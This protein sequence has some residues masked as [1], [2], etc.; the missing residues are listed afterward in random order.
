MLAKK[1][2]LCL[3]Q[4]VGPAVI[5][6][7]LCCSL[8]HPLPLEPGKPDPTYVGM[9]QIEAAGRSFLQ[10]ANDSEATSDEKPVFSAGFSYNYWLDTTD[11]TQ[12]EYTGITGKIPV[13]DSSGFGVGD[14]YPVYNVSWLD[15]ALFCNAKSKKEHLDTVYSYYGTPQVQNGSVYDIAG[16]QIHYDRNGFRLP[17]ESEWEFAARE[18][19]SRIP[20]PGLE[21]TATADSYAWYSANSQGK[22][23]PV[24]GR[25]PN[26]YGLYDMAGNVYEWTG[27]WKG[28]YST[29]SII[30]SIGA[31]MP[32]SDIEKVIKGGSFESGFISLRPSRRGAT[33]PSSQSTVA[34]YIGFRCARGIIAGP[35]FINGDTSSA[36]TNPAVLTVTSIMPIIGTSDARVVFVN[37]TG[38]IRTLCFVDFSGSYPIVREV[39]DI[40]TVYDPA[41]SPNGKY[42]AFCTRNAIGST[43]ESA[44]YVRKL[45]S[46]SSPPVKLASDS[47][48]V[49]R[50]WVDP[51]LKDTFLIYTNSAID[52]TSACGPARKH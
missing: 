9:K 26:A 1:N 31:Q 42:V 15:A 52:N 32:N 10:G 19:S 5:G 14:R 36:L 21:D 7:L 47:A 22:T 12:K 37:V 39:K 3:L 16:M 18:G 13:S 20:F 30:N 46:L 27:D 25:L 28:P 35:A 51:S 11:V 34:E 38:N 41:I 50:W 45:D 6:A 33:Y 29:S 48:F 17:T 23:N 44:I 8:F 43:G 40:Q 2:I 4:C 24:A 49:P